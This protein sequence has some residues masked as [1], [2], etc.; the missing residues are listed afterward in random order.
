MTIQDF[1]RILRERWVIVVSA[2]VI[3]VATSGA[4]WFLRPPEYTARITLYVSAQLAGTANAAYQGSLLSQE[5]V[6]SYVELLKSPRVS[7]EVIEELAL[8]ATPESVS[9]QITATTA[10]DS[11]LI[12]VAVA[13]STPEQVTQIADSVGR[14]FTRLVAELEHPSIPGDVAPVVVRVVQPA[15]VPTT[16]SSTGLP[17]ALVLG[18]L[19][20]LGGGFGLAFARSVTDTS[21]TRTEQLRELAQAPN[22]GT[23]AYDNSVPQRP[24]TLHESSQSPR[25]EAFRQLR[26]NLNYIDVDQPRKVIVVTSSMPGEGKTTSVCN[27]AIALAATDSRV[28]VLEA[29][30]RRPKLADLLGVDRSVG[31]TDV[32][33]G[34]LQPEQVI[35]SAAGGQLHIIASGPLPPNPSE[36]L[37]SQH[38]AALLAELRRHY[39]T[40]LID[41]PPLLPVTD[42][43]A[44]APSTDGAI[45]VCR[46]RSTRR[47]QLVRAVDALEAVSAK[48]LGTV[49]T[50]VPTSGPGAYAKYN[51]YYRAAEPSTD[52]RPLSPL[53]TKMRVSAVGSPRHLNS[54]PVRH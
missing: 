44:L 37:A 24:L 36:L 40:V 16:P 19:V 25:S 31:L 30:L 20:G 3:A 41:T 39:D 42:A 50:M 38:M 45:L 8:A 13:G 33:S 6:T 48:L 47:E 54:T 49:F 27:L 14:V 23:I 4:I 18:L 12:D 46:F 15:S 11:V 29:D 1:L 21:I 32:L 26:T 9:D 28:V 52:V 34:R 35:Q 22:L 7:G 5:R 43:A 51:G 17:T 53:P 2:V 10:P